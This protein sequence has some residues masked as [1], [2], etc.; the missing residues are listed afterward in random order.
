MS[1]KR[2]SWR[3]TMPVA[4]RRRMTARE[5]SCRKLRKM[6]ECFDGGDGVVL[7]SSIS[8]SCGRVM[9]VPVGPIP[10]DMATV[11]VEGGRE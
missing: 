8:C 9:S 2:K 3:L 6:C 10:P 11:V 5:L 7:V 4:E 1:T